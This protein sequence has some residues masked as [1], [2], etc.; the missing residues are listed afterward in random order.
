MI[1]RGTGRRG[2]TT[3]RSA[4]TRLTV[5]RAREHVHLVH[6]GGTPPQ[7]LAEIADWLG[8][9]RPDEAVV[10]VGAALGTD[11]VEGLCE[12]LAPVLGEFKDEEVRLLRLVMSA[13]ADEADGR[14]STARLLCERWALDVLATAGPAVV[15]PDGTLFSPDLPDAPGGWWHFSVGDVPRPVGSRLP[16]PDW[17]SALERL[18]LDAVPDHVVEPV[19]AGLM[20]RPTG[21]PSAAV[22]TLPYAVPPDPDRPHLLVDAPGVSAAGLATVIA[23]LPGRVRKDIRLLSLDGR[24]LLETGQ[25]VADLLGTDV[26]VAN[27]VPVVV[28]GGEAGDGAA[29][30]GA[31]GTAS[32]ELYLV[33]GEGTPAWRPFAETLT[34][35]PATDGRRQGTRVTSWR[36]PA[37]LLEGTEHDALPFGRTWKVAVT[38]AGLWAGPRSGEPPLVAATRTAGADT[39]AIELGTPRRALDDALWPSLDRLFGELEPEVRERAVVHVHGVLGR[40]GMEN[41]RRLTVRHDFSLMP[42]SREEAETEEGAPASAVTAVAA[43]TAASVV[44]AASAIA[45]VGAE[46]SAEGEVS[47]V[48][49]TGVR[50]VSSSGAE[51]FPSLGRTPAVEEREQVPGAAPR[52]AGRA[53]T[54]REAVDGTAR[55]A[56]ELPTRTG[57]SE[58]AATSAPSPTTAAAPTPS[59]T[60][61]SAPTP[62]PSIAVEPGPSSSAVGASAS[63]TVVERAS[64]RPEEQTAPTSLGRPAPASSTAP[65]SAPNSAS[66]TAPASAPNS[67]SSTAPSSAPNSASSTAPS[68]AS[69]SAPNAASSSAPGSPAAVAVTGGAFLSAPVQEVPVA[70]SAVV[71]ASARADTPAVPASTASSATKEPTGSAGAPAARAG[72]GDGPDHEK[73]RAHLGP[74][75]KQHRAAVAQITERLFAANPPAQSEVTI[76]ELVAV[77]VYMT[78]V[79]D[80][81][82]RAALAQGDDQSRTLL[83]CLRSGMRRLPSYRGATSSTAA[84]LVSR[85]TPEAVGEEWTGTLPV[86]A[87]SVGRTY[88]GPATDHVLIWSVTGRRTGTRPGDDGQDILFTRES[89]FRVLGVTRHGAATVGLLQELPQQAH[90]SSPQLDAALLER[91]RAVLDL[92]AAEPGRDAGPPPAQRSGPVPFP[93]PEA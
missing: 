50:S 43:T 46:V 35:A 18:D 4:V 40:N 41:L 59:P 42:Q 20:I 86:R 27:G 45:A 89:R 87:V 23:A 52:A 72:R 57:T 34:C 74:F 90:A 66:S 85:V 11:G 30:D 51:A 44:T 17:E 49:E 62:S 78:A 8:P 81:Q 26:H 31:E 71:G 68:S 80:G 91:L 21:T 25:E 48:G 22:H 84:E 55:D 58:P 77:H 69:A 76:A 65:S 36:A 92:P 5:T 13:G 53:F 61:A 38:P 32:T 33:D 15:V 54:E 63:A 16:I 2:G 73:L 75:W 7:R 3:D 1:R 47:A 24:S 19:P 10:L 64:A 37:A 28:E 14:P 93:N 79:D 60:T 56:R 88:P 6:T 70:P 82:L 12:R 83:S 29:G 9:A 39:V 67:A